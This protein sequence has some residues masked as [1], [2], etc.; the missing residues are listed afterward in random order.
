MSR[1]RS[2][3]RRTSEALYLLQR[4]RDEAHRF[5][6]TYHRAKRSK[7]M[8][9]SALDDVA[10]L[11]AVRRKALVRH[12]GSVSALRRAGVEDILEVPG[13][14]RRT[15]EAVVAALARDSA[16][17][18]ATRSA[19]SGPPSPRGQRKGRE[20]LPIRSTPIR[21]VSIEDVSIEDVSIGD[22]SVGDVSVN[23]VSVGDV[24]TESSVSTGSSVSAGSGSAASQGG[25]AADG[26]S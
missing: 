11:G 14:G 10:G 17:A 19:T 26:N 13:L 3:S 22:V 1:I 18:T 21:S 24:P 2:S 15:A 9:V 16:A 23:D 20:Q 8:T 5:A 12:F 7:S 6:I 4:L 25:E